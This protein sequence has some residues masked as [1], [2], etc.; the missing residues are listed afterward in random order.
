MS[1]W[2]GIDVGTAFIA[3]AVCRQ[4]PDRHVQLEMVPLG[5]RSDSVRS[6]VYLGADGEVVVGEAAERRAGADPDRVVH[7]RWWSM[8]SSTRLRN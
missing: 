3:A 8:G 2:L 4:Q 7:G 1:Y 5:T 6:V